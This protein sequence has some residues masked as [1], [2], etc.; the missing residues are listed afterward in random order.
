MTKILDRARACGLRVQDKR[1]MRGRR[2]TLSS[3]CGTIWSMWYIKQD[4]PIEQYRLTIHGW[5][6]L[7]DNIEN[8]SIKIRKYK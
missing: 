2:I 8:G 4:T 7:C 1:T 6:V 5:Q 3:V